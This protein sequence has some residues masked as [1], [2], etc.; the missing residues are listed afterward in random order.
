M[1]TNAVN[2]DSPV[3]PGHSGRGSPHPE[4]RRFWKTDRDGSE[5][6]TTAARCFPFVLKS[7][8]RCCHAA[9]S[10]HCTEVRVHVLIL[11]LSGRS[12]R[13]AFAPFAQ[14]RH[15]YTESRPKISTAAKNWWKAK[16]HQCSENYTSAEDG[17]RWLLASQI[18]MMSLAKQQ[19]QQSQE[20][21][22]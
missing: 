14:V 9:A 18:R 3:K 10:A 15:I 6:L 12:N 8:P 22:A 19:S 7:D 20:S 4:R 5:T 1:N 16:T 17:L 2:T 21:Q 13:G 11:S